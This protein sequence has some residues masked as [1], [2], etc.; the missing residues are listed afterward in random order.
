[1][2]QEIELEGIKGERER[3]RKSVATNHVTHGIFLE[4]KLVG[5]VKEYIFYFLHGDGYLAF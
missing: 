5:E 2:H 1:M 3:K 4:S